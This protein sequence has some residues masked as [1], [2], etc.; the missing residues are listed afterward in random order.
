VYAYC[1]PNQ[2]STPVFLFKGEERREKK[3]SYIIETSS[4]NACPS[5]NG[6][7]G[8]NKP[9]GELGVMGLLMIL[10]VFLLALCIC[11]LAVVFALL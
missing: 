8:N 6:G 11:F 3:S 4:A 5:S 2:K 10:Y 9:L 1:D 7:G